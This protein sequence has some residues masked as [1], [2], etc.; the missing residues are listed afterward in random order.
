MGM[1]TTANRLLHWG[2]FFA[3]LVLAY[4][5]TMNMI[6]YSKEAIMKTFEFSFNALGYQDI[7]P[8]DRLFI[9]RLERRESWMVHYYAGV[10]FIVL[11][12][13]RF[14]IFLLSNQ[15]RYGW[16]HISLFAII[17]TQFITGYS[18]WAYP[19]IYEWQNTTRAIHHWSI[20]AL[21]GVVG[22]HI[23][24]IIYGEV[25]GK[26]SGAVSKMIG[27]IHPKSVEKE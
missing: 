10:V 19:H 25:S 24:K 26:G 13:V 27:G 12:S 20:W 15:K 18:L 8:L 22:L 2:I 17:M 6:F 23:V 4:T 9:A 11:S 5:E 16:L 14:G 21:Y 3:L 7:P 1:Y